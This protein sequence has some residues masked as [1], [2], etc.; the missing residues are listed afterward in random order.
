MFAAKNF[1][2]IVGVLKS[3]SKR[4]FSQYFIKIL[5]FL[6]NFIFNYFGNVN[7]FGGIKSRSTL[8]GVFHVKTLVDDFFI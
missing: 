8:D 7:V 2:L 1:P 3:G 6:K 4:I 5:M